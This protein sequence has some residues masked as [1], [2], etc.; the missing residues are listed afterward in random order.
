MASLAHNS[1]VMNY[2]KKAPKVVTLDVP[3]KSGRPR[4]EDEGKTLSVTQPWVKF[5]MSR[6]TWY[7]RQAELKLKE[8]A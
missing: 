3:R 7:R 8:K 4:I 1:R 6:R 2:K 5:R